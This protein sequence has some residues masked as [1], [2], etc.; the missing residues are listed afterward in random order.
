VTAITPAAHSGSRDH[1]QSL[2]AQLPTELGG[3][4]VVLD[5]RDLTVATPSFLDEIVKIT[6]VERDAAGLEVVNASER[7]RQL[8]ERA[9]QNRDVSGRVRIDVRVA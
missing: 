9:A 3:H 8:L 5:C 6:L 2:L 1:A 4:S 7:V